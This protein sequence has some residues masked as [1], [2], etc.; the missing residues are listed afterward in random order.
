MYENPF[1]YTVQTSLLRDDAIAW[2]YAQDV[3]TSARN[4]AATDCTPNRDAYG[5]HIVLAAGDTVYDSGVESF[6]SQLNLGVQVLEEIVNKLGMSSDALDFAE[7]LADT[8]I[9]SARG[10]R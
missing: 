5:G 1:E 4:I 9:K 8:T 6:V 10:N 2:A 3:L 7:Q